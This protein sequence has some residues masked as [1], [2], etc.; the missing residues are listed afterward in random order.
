MGNGLV[1]SGAAI[2]RLEFESYLPGFV[3]PLGTGS[4]LSLLPGIKQLSE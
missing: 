4:E 3:L 1:D 2:V